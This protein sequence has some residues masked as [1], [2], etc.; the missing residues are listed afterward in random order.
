MGWV[1]KLFKPL[2]V[3]RCLLKTKKGGPRHAQP[4]LSWISLLCAA[5]DLLHGDRF[6]RAYVHARAAIAAGIGIDYGQTV[7]HRNGVQRARLDTSLATGA[8]FRINYC[9]HE[10]SP[11][12][13]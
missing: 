1:L 4:A 6:H 2:A 10:L 12:A 13:R 5:P 7:F 11:K 9:W 8:L 3:S